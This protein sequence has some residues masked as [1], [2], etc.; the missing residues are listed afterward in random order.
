MPL[1][2]VQEPGESDA[3]IAAVACGSRFANNIRPFA[4]HTL[5]GSIRARSCT[6]THSRNQRELALPCR[7][8]FDTRHTVALLVQCHTRR[9]FAMAA[10]VIKLHNEGQFV[11]VLPR[12]EGVYL[13][14][15]RETVEA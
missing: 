15:W 13:F 4:G 6:E 8:L 14:H 9:A 10:N 3:T 11:R 5:S 7:S 1:L 12:L 2:K